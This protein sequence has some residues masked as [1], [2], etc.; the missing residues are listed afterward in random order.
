MDLLIYFILNGQPNPVK[1][2]NGF[3]LTARVNLEQRTV[4]YKC[5]KWNPS[6]ENWQGGF[7]LPEEDVNK[8]C[9]NGTVAKNSKFCA[10]PRPLEQ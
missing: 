9:D 8:L 10:I 3:L 7:N 1:C 2:S 4:K 6:L 5:V